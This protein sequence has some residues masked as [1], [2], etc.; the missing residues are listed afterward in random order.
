MGG[1]DK[2]QNVVPINGNCFQRKIKFIATS[3]ILQ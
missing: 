1:Y 3:Y 2:L